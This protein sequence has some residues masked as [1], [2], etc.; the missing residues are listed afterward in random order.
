MPS[1]MSIALAFSFNV[2]IEVKPEGI[3]GSLILMLLGLSVLGTSPPSIALNSVILFFV[4]W[5]K[6][7]PIPP[8]F[9]QQ[10]MVH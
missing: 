9:Y 8:C 4:S 7:L 5:N 1:V 6:E 3:K 2:Q 10:V